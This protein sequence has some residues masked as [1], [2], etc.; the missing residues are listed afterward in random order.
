MKSFVCGGVGEHEL[1][2]MRAMP[3]RKPRKQ[4]AMPNSLPGQT[5]RA[6]M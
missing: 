1:K 4:K 3:S 5:I 6:F 2:V